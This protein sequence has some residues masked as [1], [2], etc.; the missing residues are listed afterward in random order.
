MR[1]QH[2]AAQ[3][4]TD[5]LELDL[6][7]VPG[8]RSSVMAT[9][10]AHALHLAAAELLEVD[11]REI[12]LSVQD[13]EEQTSWKIQLYDTEAGASGHILE[14]VERHLELKLALILVLSRDEQHN[15]TCS[16]A[17]LALIAAVAPHLV[18]FAVQ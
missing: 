7:E 6:E 2:L 9:A 11:A 16:N 13:I 18:L 5:L 8:L 12:S 17:G 4:N 14:L 15:A 3:H 10:L 1:Y